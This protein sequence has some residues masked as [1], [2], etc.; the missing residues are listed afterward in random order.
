MSVAASWFEARTTDAPPALV[1]RA[2]EYFAACPE[3]PLVDRLATAGEEALRAATASG[4]TRDA[5][6]DLLAADALITLALLACAEHHPATLARE[7]KALR[8]TAMVA[9]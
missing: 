2:S 6:L 1:A 5:A 7:A 9:S 3:L 4:S 8:V